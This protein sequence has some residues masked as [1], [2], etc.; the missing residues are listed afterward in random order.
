MGIHG[1]EFTAIHFFENWNIHQV[2]LSCLL[3]TT[4]W[5][6]KKIIVNYDTYKKSHIIWC[7]LN[8][9]SI[10]GKSREAESGLVIS[11]DQGVDIHV[12]LERD[13]IWLVTSCPVSCPPKST[14]FSHAQHECIHFISVN[15]EPL[16][17]FQHHF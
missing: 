13:A 3:P 1:N 11:R 6:L 12:D 8:E 2:C 9:T 15:C 5:I 17:L 14:S 7:L 10:I 16:G 4:V